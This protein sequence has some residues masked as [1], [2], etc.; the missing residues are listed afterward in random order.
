MVL[1]DEHKADRRHESVHRADR[2]GVFGRHRAPQRGWPPRLPDRSRCSFQPSGRTGS[3]P[4]PEH[5]PSCSLPAVE[6]HHFALAAVFQPGAVHQFMSARVP[7]LVPN[8][9]L[10]RATSLI[11]LVELLQER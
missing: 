3:P 4:R 6:N 5:G 11:A 9:E 1:M 10:R 7:D 8:E 2:V